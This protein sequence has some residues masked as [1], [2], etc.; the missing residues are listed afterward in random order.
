MSHLLPKIIYHKFTLY[1][2][3]NFLITNVMFT[4]MELAIISGFCFVTKWLPKAV[5]LIVF[6]P[7]IL[8]VYDN[9]FNQLQ[10]QE[11]QQS[12]CKNYLTL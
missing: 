3:V 7:N 2:M 9:L 12:Q 1:K 4:A 5:F 8:A 6:R 10:W 11:L